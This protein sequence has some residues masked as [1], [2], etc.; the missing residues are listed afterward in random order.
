MLKKSK[1]DYYYYTYN[2]RYKG[3]PEVY[4]Q[5]C[6]F[7]NSIIWKIHRR[8]FIQS[9]HV[10]SR[11]M[12]VTMDVYKDADYS[13]NPKRPAAKFETGNFQILDR[14][15]HYWQLTL[16]FK[17]FHTL[18]LEC[19]EIHLPCFEPYIYENHMIMAIYV[20]A[21]WYRISYRRGR[22]KTK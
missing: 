21:K 17:R 7:R 16:I 8:H 20:P 22:R 12:K 18:F 4:I 13:I 9:T 5:T 19:H 6:K 2:C 10:L 15:H 3:E 1:T 14:V 11:R